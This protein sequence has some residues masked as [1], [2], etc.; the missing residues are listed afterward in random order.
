MT[1]IC[2]A[3]L[4]QRREETREELLMMILDIG[5]VHMGEARPLD[6]LIYM[7]CRKRI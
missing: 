1:L 4:L 5:W 2:T 7:V 6:N 3:C